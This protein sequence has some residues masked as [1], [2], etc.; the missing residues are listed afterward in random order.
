VAKQPVDVEFVRT[1]HNKQL[2]TTSSHILSSPTPSLH[3]HPQ[4]AAADTGASSRH[5][6]GISNAVYLDNVEIATQPIT[7]ELPNH[8][9]IVSAPTPTQHLDDS[10]TGGAL[11]PRPGIIRGQ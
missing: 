2:I 10:T 6:L 7:V 8:T 11:I 1:P 5:F 4:A 3:T 9:Q